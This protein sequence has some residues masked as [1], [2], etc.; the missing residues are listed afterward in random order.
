MAFIDDFDVDVT[1]EGSYSASSSYVPPPLPAPGL[2]SPWS[3]R[4]RW[5]GESHRNQT[6]GWRDMGGYTPYHGTGKD[7]RE[8]ARKKLQKAK[9]KAAAEAA[10]LSP[11]GKRQKEG[12]PFM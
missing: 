9:K 1:D 11:K 12:K 3:S 2:P 10:D 6:E 7:Q 4:F 5:G 8:N